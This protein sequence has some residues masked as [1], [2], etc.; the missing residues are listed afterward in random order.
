[1]ELD[2][3]AATLADVDALTPLMREY[4]EY[5]GIPFDE[6]KARKAL[7]GFLSHDSFGR[8]W[9]V[10]QADAIAGYIVLTYDYGLESGGRE[11]FIDEFYLR[12]AYRGQGI[13]R[14]TIEFAE[15]FCA[16]NGIRTLLLGVEPENTAAQAFYRK[17]GFEDRRL[18]IWTK[19]I[20]KER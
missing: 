16:A 14:K 12:A 20:V 2:F 8:A 13:G 6:A 5:D 3:K 10:C 4:Y 9:L 1:M 19:P 7:A 17:V 18:R 15:Q 11:A